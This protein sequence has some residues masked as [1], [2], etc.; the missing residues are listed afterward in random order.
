MKKFFALIVVAVVMLACSCVAMAEDWQTRDQYNRTNLAAAEQARPQD[1]VTG[2]QTIGPRKSGWGIGSEIYHFKYKEPGLMEEKGTM[3]GLQVDYTMRHEAMVRIEGRFAWGEVD[4]TSNGS[5]EAEDID[6]FT[7][8]LRGLIGLD[9]E[10]GDLYFTPFI[11]VGYRHLSDDGGGKRT[12][13]SHLMYDRNS[14]YF[15]SPLGADFGL[16]L[17][18]GWFWTTSAEYDFFWEGEQESELSTAVAG[19]NDVDNDQDDGYGVRVS[20]RFQKQ[21]EH[22]DVL[23]EP[24]WRRWQIDESD[25]SLITYQGVAVGYGVEPKNRTDETGARVSLLF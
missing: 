8:E 18:D 23:I 21:T 3:Y 4:Y 19:L 20:M 10:L 6:D 14:H 5:G 11:G 16:A 1:Q 22:F 17:P 13:T 7:A 9:F 25:S 24:F 2:H 15:Y 12:T